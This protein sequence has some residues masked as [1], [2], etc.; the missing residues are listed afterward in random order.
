M[1]QKGC[2]GNSQYSCTIFSLFIPTV[3]IQC[4]TKYCGFKSIHSQFYIC[5]Y[6]LYVTRTTCFGLSILGHLQV[7]RSLCSLQCQVWCGYLL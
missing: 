3:F 6:L 2:Q 5:I 7:R 1:N 4:F